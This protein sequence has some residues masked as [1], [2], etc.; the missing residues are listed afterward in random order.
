MI[1][2]SFKTYVKYDFKRTDK[3]T[4]LVQA[5]NDSIVHVS[6]LIP[7]SVYKYQSYVATVTSREEYPIPATAL[8]I[9]HPA[10]LLDGS[11]SSDSGTI[12]EHIDKQTYDI[13]E[14]NPNRTSPATGRPNAYTIFAGAYLLSPIPDKSTYLLE[15]DWTKKPTALSADADAPALGSEWDEVL[16]WMTLDRLFAGLGLYDEANYWR[17]K[18]E[19]SQ[20]NPVG[21]L[22][23]LLDIERD[24]EGVTIGR[25]R[26]NSL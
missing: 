13:R 3:D 26:N 24:R 21:L 16:K 1:L 8:H 9:I 25:V 12:L 2:S 20:G 15:I 10:R 11:A 5:Y 23:R 22:K 17:G 19:D 6:I 7:N 14:T 18:Y 4:E